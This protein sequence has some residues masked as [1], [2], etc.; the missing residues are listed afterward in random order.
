MR[1][2]RLGGIVA[3]DVLK[4]GAQEDQTAGA[5]LAFPGL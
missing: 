4:V 5:A 3:G 1:Q 2:S